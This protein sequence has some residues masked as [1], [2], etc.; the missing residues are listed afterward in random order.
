MGWLW[1]CEG[2]E[3]S[4]SGCGGD[5]RG[6]VGN[7]PEKSLPRKCL[8]GTSGHSEEAEVE[9]EVRIEITFACGGFLF[10][11]VG[12]F[13]LSLKVPRLVCSASSK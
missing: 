12:L 5:H 13:F 3:G 7:E 9:V 10:Y 2:K 8:S 1:R 11:L 6:N 4:G